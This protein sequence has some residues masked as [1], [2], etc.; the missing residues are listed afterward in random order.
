ML[1]LGN[2]KKWKEDEC[3]Q[4]TKLFCSICSTFF[5]CLLF[6]ALHFFVCS[7]ESALS[8]AAI[9]FVLRFLSQL[10]S[11][12]S[13]IFCNNVASQ[14]TRLNEMNCEKCAPASV[15]VS[16]RSRD[17]FVGGLG[18]WVVGWVVAVQ[19]L[20]WPLSNSIT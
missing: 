2:V 4:K 5:L 8:Y 11:I 20:S 16:R 14:Q 13:N 10:S 12:L 15:S 6:K 17:F 3:K 19:W 7:C 9:F 1:P 18:D